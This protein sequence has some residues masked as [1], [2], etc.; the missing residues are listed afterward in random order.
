MKLFA[1]FVSVLVLIDLYCQSR[2]QSYSKAHRFA[3]VM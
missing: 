1:L 2:Q 3:M